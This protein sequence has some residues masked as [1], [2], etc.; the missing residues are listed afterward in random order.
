M[1]SSGHLAKNSDGN[2]PTNFSFVSNCC[3]QLKL[4]LFPIGLNCSP[5]LAE[6]AC[7]LRQEWAGALPKATLKKYN[8]EPL[9]CSS[10]GWQVVEGFAV[11]VPDIFVTHCWEQSCTVESIIL[12]IIYDNGNNHSLSLTSWRLDLSFPPG[13]PRS[14]CLCLVSFFEAVCTSLS[15]PCAALTSWSLTELNSTI[16]ITRFLQQLLNCVF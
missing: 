12:G 16:L 13:N 14:V 15:H 8:A 4:I 11:I 6:L 3:F 7:F 2:K 9:L 5:S 10:Q 1:K